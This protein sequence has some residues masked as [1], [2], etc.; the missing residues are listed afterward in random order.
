M[1]NP[2]RDLT[3]TLLG[4][5]C[6][7]LLIVAA[8]WIVQPFVA[9]AIW[10]TTI[11]VVTWPLMLRIQARLWNYRILAVASMITA[12]ILL[13]V[14][15]LTLAIGAIVAN[16]DA[17][18]DQIRSITSMPIPPPP[19]WVVQLPFI[20]TAF[21]AAWVEA[22]AAGV[23]GL[24]SHLIPYAGGFT[25]WLFAEIGSA[26]YLV[27]QLLLIP[28]FAAFM[29]QYGERYA[30]TL[31]RFGFRLGGKQGEAL[32]ILAGNAIRGVALGVGVTAVI[33]SAL[34]GVGLMLAGVPFAGLLTLLL[35]VLCVAQIGML[36]VLIPAVVWV[37]WSGD[38]AWGMF[39]LIWSVPASML[40]TWL[41]PLLVSR[42]ANLPLLLIFVG[43]IGGFVAFGVLGIFVGPVVLAV[44]Y[45]FLKT[46]LD[47]SA[48]RTSDAP[49][50]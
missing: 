30:S 34:G 46:W 9:A 18:V 47:E 12:L 36:V 7:G 1:A 35:L 38:P 39:L 28:V 6:I 29:Y 42:S 37:F 44:A 43:V 15:P 45:T 14:I 13:F 11:V 22:S 5:L 2:E 19:N 4:V 10:A 25:T 41:R 3:R 31:L 27:I 50:R 21:A 16:A 8:L 20:G 26:G 33:Q 40:D 23:E 24:V 49:P 48:T 17:I 32:I